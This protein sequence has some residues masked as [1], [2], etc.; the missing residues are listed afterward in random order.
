M[1]HFNVNG[2]YPRDEAMEKVPILSLRVHLHETLF[3]TG[4]VGRRQPLLC[5]VTWAIK[6]HSRRDVVAG[7]ASAI[8]VV[9]PLIKHHCCKCTN[10]ANMAAFAPNV[11]LCPLEDVSTDMPNPISCRDPHEFSPGRAVAAKLAPG[12]AQK[13]NTHYSR[14]AREKTSNR[15]Q[16]LAPSALEESSITSFKTTTAADDESRNEEIVSCDVVAH[17]QVQEP[18]QMHTSQASMPFLSRSTAPSRNN[19]FGKND[20][21]V[22]EISQWYF[23]CQLPEKDY[24]FFRSVRDNWVKDIWDM[25]RN[26]QSMFAVLSAFALHKKAT[27]AGSHA[28][29]Q[30]YEQKSQIIQNIVAD[31][32][33]SSD[34]PDRTTVVAMAILAYFD[35]RDH[36]F[37]A[38]GMHLRAVRNFIDMPSMSSQGWLYC[39]WAD[40]RQALFT[41]TEPCLPFYVPVVFRE[42]HHTLRFPQ[43]E[44]FRMGAVNASQCPRSPIFTL[45]MASD[46][47]GKLHALCYCSDVPAPSGTPSFGQVYALEYG[48][49]VVQARAK[50]SESD[51]FT[52]PIMLV[53][54]AIQ[55]H[56][57]MAARFYTPQARETHLG[58]IAVASENLDS[59]EDMITQWY[60]AA[61]L[62]SLLWVLF[63]MVASLRAHELPQTTKVLGLLYQALR[64]AHINSC[65]NLEASLKH[66]PWLANW[67]PVQ[68][69]VVWEMLCAQYPDLVPRT[70][71]PDILETHLDPNK[72]RHRWFLGGLEF[73]NSL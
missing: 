72:A 61:G 52:S 48:L 32:K 46:L 45:D 24:E 28:K 2:D 23:L 70:A 29:L 18:F 43:R 6:A 66:W 1:C 50:R 27:L 20:G 11:D 21:D 37:D 55:L 9:D 36:Q 39:A 34:G 56:V 33:Q 69:S 17:G 38:A 42:V 62:E 71:R 67:H 3:R 60:I 44:A 8:R 65:D 13:P 35:I 68:I 25:G 26:S 30:Y 73:Y 4:R 41:T 47:F 57:W 53:T 64:K 59:F 16:L 22:Q 12:M 51:I 10:L 49:R 5:G 7:R 15:R 54:S 19:L 40:L 63:T 14:R 58:L 31:I